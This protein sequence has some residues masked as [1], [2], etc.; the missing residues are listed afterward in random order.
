M[1]GIIN[2]Y[3]DKVVKNNVFIRKASRDNN[4][5]LRFFIRL[6]WSRFFYTGMWFL[7]FFY[8][9]LYNFITKIKTKPYARI[10]RVGLLKP[11][12]NVNIGHNAH[13]V[14]NLLA[15]V[16]CALVFPQQSVTSLYTSLFSSVPLIYRSMPYT[17]VQDDYLEGIPLKMFGV[18]AYAYENSS[19]YPENQGFLVNEKDTVPSGLMRIDPCRYGNINFCFCSSHD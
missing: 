7:R 8:F 2:P 3:F 11:K 9:N 14:S 12:I 18:P 16:L 1:S 15:F 17:F 13:K 6:I 10:C 4:K 19:T 5:V